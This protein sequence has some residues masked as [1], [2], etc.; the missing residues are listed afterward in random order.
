MT[1]RNHALS[2]SSTRAVAI[3][4]GHGKIALLLGDLLVRGGVDVRGLI[5]NRE[6]RADLEA[7]GVVPVIADLERDDSE[8]P[9]LIAGVDAVVFAAGAGP[10]SGAA[11]KRTM[12]RDGA[13]RLIAACEQAEVRR[14]VMISAMGAR[15]E[16]GPGDDVFTIYLR[17]KRDA[18]QALA[19]SS[20]DYTILRPGALTDDPPTGR[21]ALAPELAAGSI[22]RADVAA[23]VAAVL[24][25][26]STVGAAFDLISGETPIEQAVASV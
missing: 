15:G 8:L 18:D 23:T 6:H 26:A 25:A 10:G 20:L 11:R 22:P 4:G 14:Y 21:V 9:G 7:I 17:A 16:I 24:G 2:S 5:R 1:D 13:L 3:A 12:D 19:A